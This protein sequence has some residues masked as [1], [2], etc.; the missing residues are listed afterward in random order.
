MEARR[1]PPLVYATATLHLL[2]HLATNG[3]YGVFRDELY[4]LACAD[5]LDWGYV[6]HPPLSIALL[7]AQRALLGESVWAIRLLPALA[8]VAVVLLAAR[9]ARELG[10]GRFAEGLAALAVAIVPQYLVITGFYSMNAFDLVFWAG[11]ALLVA[12]IVNT[13]D[14]RLWLVLGALLGLGLQNKLSVLFFGFGLAVA[15]LLTPLRSHLLRPQ[16][17]LGGLLAAAL[18]LPHLLWQVGHDWPTLEFIRNAKLHKIAP[19]S[20]MQFFSA[21]FLEI[22]PVNAPLWLGGLLWLLA[23]REGRKFR[24][25]GHHLRRGV[26][27][28]GLQKSKPYYLGPAYPMLLAA[29]AVAFEGLSRT[30]AFLRPVLVS[31]LVVGGLAVAPLVVPLLPVERLIAYQRALGLGPGGRGADGNGAAAPALRRP[32]RLGGDDGG[33]GRSLPGAPREREGLGPHRHVELRR[34]G[35]APLLRSATRPSRG[36]QPAQ[37]LLPV[38]TGARTARTW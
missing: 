17:W 25:F 5:H 19:L 10:G 8:G 15:L 37:Q 34:G 36:G 23:G 6:D 24:V 18:F 4:Y 12:R 20:P 14:A 11:A 1:F 35:S 29:G 27:D 26:R 3:R 16:L 31:L 22:H 9:L 21:Q 13:G 38:G 2:L 33:G 30:R 28:D 32:L 7:W